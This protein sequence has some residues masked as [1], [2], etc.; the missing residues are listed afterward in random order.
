MKLNY[1]GVSYETGAT[2]FEKTE[3]EYTG[4]FLGQMFPI[5]AGT[6]APR[7]TSAAAMCYRGVNYL[8]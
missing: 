4:H 1:R 3:T 8:R 7:F 5:K 6:P 2:S